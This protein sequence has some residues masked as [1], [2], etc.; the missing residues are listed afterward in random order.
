VPEV[1]LQFEHIE[2]SF[3]PAGSRQSGSGVIVEAEGA[4]LEI[5]RVAGE[6]WIQSP[7][8]WIVV[9]VRKG[10]REIEVVVRLIDGSYQLPV[11]V[12]LRRLCVTRR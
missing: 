6:D 8:R 12:D 3:L 11:R 5:L 2:V 7:H 10:T 1:I 4:R 9:P